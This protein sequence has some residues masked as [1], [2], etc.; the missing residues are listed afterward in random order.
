M[1]G[2]PALCAPALLPGSG[3]LL[4]LLRLHLSLLSYLDA[5]SYPPAFFCCEKTY[6]V[7][8]N[9]RTEGA[10]GSESAAISPLNKC[11]IQSLSATPKHTHTSLLY[12][13][14]THTNTLTAFKFQVRPPP[15]TLTHRHTHTHTHFV[16][17]FV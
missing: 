15:P 14:S 7:L 3:S 4:L 12:G 17:F 5:F 1:G 2:T 6:Y 10:T 8:Q 13:V 9:K 16:L 11:L